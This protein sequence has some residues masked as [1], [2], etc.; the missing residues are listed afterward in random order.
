[1]FHDIGTTREQ[2]LSDLFINTHKCDYYYFTLFINTHK[3]D[4]YF[5]T[6]FINTHKCDY[7]Y[8]ILVLNDL[9][10]ILN[11]ILLVMMNCHYNIP[12]NSNRSN[13]G[14]SDLTTINS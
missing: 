4:N 9:Q 3:C 13:Q 5:F 12:Y 6:L 7:Y 8:F 14:V 11:N 2:L 10:Y 1:M